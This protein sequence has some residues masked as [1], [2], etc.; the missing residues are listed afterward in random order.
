MT[1][2]KT[3]KK[4]WPSEEG[5]SHSV[6]KITPSQMGVYPFAI[7]TDRLSAWPAHSLNGHS[8]MAQQP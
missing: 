8:H 1:P 3:V 7:Q 5:K 6:P 4:K 2:G